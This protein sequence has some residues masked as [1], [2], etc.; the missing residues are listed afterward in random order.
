MEFVPTVEDVTKYLLEGLAVAVAAFY[1]PRKKTDLQAVAM[2]AVTAA[3]SFYVLD[4]FAPRVAAGSRQGAGFGI[5]FGMVGGGCS[6]KSA[7]TASEGFSDDSSS[8][9]Y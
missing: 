3:L 4:K 7:P 8:S 2:I 6:A 1:L 9:D 5:G